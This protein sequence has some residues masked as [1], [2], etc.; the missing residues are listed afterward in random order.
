M[1]L[2]VNPAVPQTPPVEDAIGPFFERS[3]GLDAWAWTQEDGYDPTA[4]GV[5]YGASPDPGRNNTD[6]TQ[7]AGIYGKVGTVGANPIPVF[8]PLHK[9]IMEAQL[10]SHPTT[11]YR[12]GPGGKAPG[13]QQTITSTEVTNYAPEPDELASIYTSI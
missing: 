3:D 1:L 2:A 12:I 10:F 11:Q 5:S 7:P 4:L 8:D 13:L 6:A 9:A